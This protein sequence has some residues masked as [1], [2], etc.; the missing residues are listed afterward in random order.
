MANIGHQEDGEFA[1]LMVN[2]SN[3]ESVEFLNGQ[4][5]LLGESRIPQWPISAIV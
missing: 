2:I 1:L 4:Y 5:W 3:W